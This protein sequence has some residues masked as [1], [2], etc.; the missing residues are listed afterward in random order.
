LISEFANSVAFQF[1]G[2]L[3]KPTQ[4]RRCAK[5]ARLLPGF[6]A[7]DNTISVAEPM[8]SAR[9]GLGSWAIWRK[10]DDLEIVYDSDVEDEMLRVEDEL[11]ED[12]DL[13]LD[14]SM[15]IACNESTLKELLPSESELQALSS[16]DNC[17]LRVGA[18]A[19][20]GTAEVIRLKN[21]V[22]HYRHGTGIL[23][24]AYG[25]HSDGKV[26]S[27]FLIAKPSASKLKSGC[28][29]P[30]AYRPDRVGA[31]DL[32]GLAEILG[33][34]DDVCAQT[35]FVTEA[36]DWHDGRVSVDLATSR[37]YAHIIR[38]FLSFL[39]VSKMADECAVETSFGALLS[40]L[41]DSVPVDVR[42]GYTGARK[43]AVGGMLSP[44]N[45]AVHGRTDSTY[46]LSGRSAKPQNPALGDVDYMF[47]TTEFK[48]DKTFTPANL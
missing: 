38:R 28:L 44:P 33:L 14:L 37:D 26:P 11:E 6:K 22:K 29:N 43:F 5:S 30:S 31:L 12:F 19:E 1:H 42:V 40:A 36:L 16:V 15:H 45:F 18:R 2:L 10:S 9:T 32:K 8:A 21:E 41:G 20:R 48:T 7:N 25:T 27:Y 13:S 47:L 17:S 3:A 39:N 35:A 46:V 4:A 34:G 24:H 23:T